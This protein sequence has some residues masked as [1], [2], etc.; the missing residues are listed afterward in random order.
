MPRLAFFRSICLAPLALAACTSVTKISDTQLEKR[1]ALNEASATEQLTKFLRYPGGICR[2]VDP[3][4]NPGL[5]KAEISKGILTFTANKKVATGGGVSGSGGT[6]YMSTTYKL[7]PTKYSTSIRTLKD[8]QIVESP[9]T[10]GCTVK[11]FDW[12]IVHPQEGPAFHINV[13]PKD[14]DDVIADFA[15]FTPNLTIKKG[16]GF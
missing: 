14:L 9:G 6:L 11:G 16:A 15:F 7:V 3:V 1:N 13:A 2:M 10:S 12:V 5:G 4:T 8:V